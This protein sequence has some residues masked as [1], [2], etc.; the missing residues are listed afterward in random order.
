MQLPTHG[1]PLHAF[2]EKTDTFNGTRIIFES[3]C[4]TTTSSMYSLK[5]YHHILDGDHQLI[6]ETILNFPHFPLYILNYDKIKKK[7]H[8][9]LLWGVVCII[10]Y[11]MLRKVKIQCFDSMSLRKKNPSEQHAIT[12]KLKGMHYVSPWNVLFVNSFE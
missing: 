11:R 9:I 10:L 7:F 8:T 1:D 5:Y 3:W 6:F 4:H 12:M 2:Q